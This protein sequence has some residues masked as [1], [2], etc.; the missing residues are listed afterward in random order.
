MK[1]GKFTEKQV[2]LIVLG[3]QIAVCAVVLALF[4]LNYIGMIII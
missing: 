1:Q 2:V 3:M 4:W